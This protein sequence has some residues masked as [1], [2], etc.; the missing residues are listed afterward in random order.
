MPPY[1]RADFHNYRPLTRQL[2]SKFS[3][4]VLENGSDTGYNFGAYSAGIELSV[5][6]IF[7]LVKLYLMLS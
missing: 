5:G 3:M 6:K 2:S 7:Q 4:D 1:E